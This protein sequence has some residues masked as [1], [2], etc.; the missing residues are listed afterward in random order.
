[1]RCRPARWTPAFTRELERRSQS[2]PRG[3]NR[4]FHRSARPWLGTISRLPT[5]ALLRSLRSS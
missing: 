4:R 3:L 2:M 1:L 5:S